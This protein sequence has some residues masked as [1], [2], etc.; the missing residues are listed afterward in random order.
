MI[1]MRNK[2][3][4]FEDSHRDNAD[5]RK[6]LAWAVFSYIDK[7][8]KEEYRKSFTAKTGTTEN[9]FW[10]IAPKIIKR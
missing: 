2:L 3:E 1:L 7:T 4:I 5:K 8:T 9:E 6:K 10:N